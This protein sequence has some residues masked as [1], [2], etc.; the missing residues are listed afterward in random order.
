VITFV[1]FKRDLLN[2]PEL[3]PTEDLDLAGEHDSGGCCRVDTVRLYRDDG[4]AAVLEE[5]FRIV[6]YDTCLVRLRNVG[7]D[8]VYRGEQHAVFLWEAGVLH[9]CYKEGR[10]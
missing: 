7:E 8:D 1:G 6:R 3:E 5:V 10:P 9:N 4:V 2:G